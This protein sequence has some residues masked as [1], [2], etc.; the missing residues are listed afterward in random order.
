MNSLLH[1]FE[2]C[3]HG[4]IRIAA[5]RAGD[6]VRLR[7]TDDGQGMNAAVAQQAFDPFFTTKLG[8]GGS[9]L[10]LYIVTSGDRRAGG[11]V[12][13]RQRTGTRRDFRLRAAVPGAATVGSGRGMHDAE[14]GRRRLR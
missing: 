7:Y 3:D 6:S 1:G 10:G 13:A 5:E 8:R 2:A 11:T 12:S 9:G 4:T 14:S